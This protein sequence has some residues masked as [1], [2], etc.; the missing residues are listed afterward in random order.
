MRVAAVRL[1]FLFYEQAFWRD[2]NNKS[3]ASCMYA[4]CYACVG[5]DFILFFFILLQVKKEINAVHW[6]ERKKKK[7]EWE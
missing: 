3:F 4:L 2:A 6:L 7:D 1:F 5:Y